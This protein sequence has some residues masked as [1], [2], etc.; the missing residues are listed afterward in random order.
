MDI[1]KLMV[2][3]N[4]SCKAVLAENIYKNVDFAGFLSKDLRRLV[5]NSRS[6]N[7]VL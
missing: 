7:L 4:V 2:Q 6:L 3:N 1:L 5:R